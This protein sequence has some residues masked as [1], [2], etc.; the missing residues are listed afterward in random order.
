[1]LGGHMTIDNLR[2]GTQ[3]LAA[4]PVRR[5]P[6]DNSPL[7]GE[8]LRWVHNLS[9]YDGVY[10]ALATLTSGVLLTGDSAL[11]AAAGRARV[12]HRHIDCTA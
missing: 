11:A 5:V 3:A 12:P 7:L 4:M 2:S 10:L 9:V 1:M 8:A 6:L